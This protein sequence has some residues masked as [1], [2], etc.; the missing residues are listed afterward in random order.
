ML[1]PYEHDDAELL[2]KSV[3]TVV[4]PVSAL[5]ARAQDEGAELIYVN[6]NYAAT[7]TRRRRS[8][9]SVRWTAPAPTWSSRSCRPRALTS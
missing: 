5:I 7:G 6:D 1:N 3:E 9:L 2:T 4:E 8:W